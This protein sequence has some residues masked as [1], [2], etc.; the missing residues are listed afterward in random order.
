MKKIKISFFL[1]LLL[2]SW[3]SSLNSAAA[4]APKPTP[5]D[6]PNG[7]CKDILIS[8]QSGNA[9]EHTTQPVVVTFTPAFDGELIM[10]YYAPLSNARK[11]VD[12]FSATANTPVTKELYDNVSLRLQ[13]TPNQGSRIEI[14]SVVN[15]QEVPFCNFTFTPQ[16][17]NIDRY[18]DCTVK[19][20]SSLGKNNK[21]EDAYFTPS[22]IISYTVQLPKITDTFGSNTQDEQAIIVNPQICTVNSFHVPNKDLKATAKTVNFG[23]CGAGNYQVNLRML[24]LGPDVDVLDKC[25][26]GFTISYDGVQ[27]NAAP[28][29]APGSSPSSFVPI[30]KLVEHC[31]IIQ[32][33]NQKVACVDCISQGEHF[34]TA[35]GCVPTNIPKFI[36]EF[37][38]QI[39][40]SL[41]GGLA[42]LRLIWGAII[43]MLSSGDPKKLLQGRDVMV[44]AILGLLLIIFGVVILRFIG[45]DVLKL[46]GF[47]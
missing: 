20:T 18:S 5:F 15:R 26:T 40:L 3:F 17:T 29:L 31:D 9:V 30:K 16:D 1:I 12:I 14:V 4:A 35:L 21:N 13:L 37:I 46:P 7:N 39:G 32:N 24:M 6:S 45:V 47:K 42:F 19:I 22:S 41:A 23:T 33:T 11:L 43:T 10:Y 25:V 8:D 2:V 34:Y 44:S 27:Q 36:Q 28:T 38:L